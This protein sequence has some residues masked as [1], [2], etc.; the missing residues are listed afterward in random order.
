PGPETVKQTEKRRC[1]A[2]KTAI[3]AFGDL[4][5]RELENA[6]ADIAAWRATLPEGSRY[7]TTQ[8]LRQVFNAALE[9]EYMFKN[10]AKKAGRNPQPVRE[11]IE[12]FE[13]EAEIDRL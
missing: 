10:P 8:A 9:W 7:G 1:R 3:E 2:H 12:I 13:S 4:T 6:A 11:E 5:L